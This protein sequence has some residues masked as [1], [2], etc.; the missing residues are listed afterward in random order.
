MGVVIG[1][2]IGGYFYQ[3]MSLDVHGTTGGPTRQDEIL[4]RKK[5]IC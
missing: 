2:S 1:A 3:T 5:S 4:G